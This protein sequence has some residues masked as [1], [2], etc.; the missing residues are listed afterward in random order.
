M[1]PALISGGAALLGGLMAKDSSRNAAGINRDMQ[2]EFA[3]NGIRWKVE[4]AKS[5]GVHPLY[6]LGASTPSFS[7]SFIGGGDSG[8]SQ[9][10]QD[11]SR[12]MRAGSTAPE[13]EAQNLHNATLAKL[14]IERATLENELL[15][16]RI[17]RENQLG[18]T[19]PAFPTGTETFPVRSGD[20]HVSAITADSVGPGVVKRVP[21]EVTS[22]S[23]SAPYAVAGTHPGGQI[24]DFGPIGKI[25]GLSP[26]A[27]Q[28]FE[29]L[30]AMKYAAILG[31]NFPKALEKF[32]G[33]RDNFEKFGKWATSNGKPD[34]VLRLEKQHGPMYQFKPGWWRPVSQRT[35]YG[36]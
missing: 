24:F 3:Q 21:S 33:W 36:D 26:A 34:W 27:S 19:G 10:G 7:P 29:D 12:A 1:L 5:A 14:S 9:M 8:V 20:I 22:A 28:S 13:R 6:A 2:R 31:M 32:K 25:T 4:D 17:V 23:P 15:K 30:E 16:S 35:F 11:I 18:Q